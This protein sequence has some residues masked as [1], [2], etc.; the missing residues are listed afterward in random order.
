MSQNNKIKRSSKK[1]AATCALLVVVG[2]S[3]VALAAPPV[4]Q[5]PG[6]HLNITNVEVQNDFNTTT[7][8][9]YGE[10]FDFGQ[11]LQI[12]LAGV[13]ITFNCG[14]IGQIVNPNKIICEFDGGLSA[15]GDYELNVSTGTG[16]SQSDEYVL[17]IGAVRPQDAPDADGGQGP[18]GDSVAGPL[19]THGTQRRTYN[20]SCGEHLDFSRP[21]S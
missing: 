21:C 8:E 7:I 20:P 18:K 13:D 3:G 5:Q 16:Q 17:T 12:T 4:E 10:D 19:L 9:I 2:F 6:G 11:P 1:A 15:A 14:W